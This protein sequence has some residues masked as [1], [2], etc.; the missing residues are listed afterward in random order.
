MA[1]NARSVGAAILLAAALGGCAASSPA[2]DETD[3]RDAVANLHSHT[4]TGRTGASDDAK[5][6]AYGFRP[7]TGG[8]A[9]CRARLRQGRAPAR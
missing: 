4:A 9:D 2:I 6:Q 8:Y 5:C 3:R 1:G 7:G